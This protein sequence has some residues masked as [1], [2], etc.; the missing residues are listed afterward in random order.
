MFSVDLYCYFWFMRQYDIYFP[1]K[2][3]AKVITKSNSGSNRPTI[4]RT[5]L[6]NI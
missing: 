2:Q 6:N 1:K 4:Q 5:S 3:Y